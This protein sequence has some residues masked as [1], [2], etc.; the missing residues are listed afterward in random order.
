MNKNLD[1]VQILTTQKIQKAF[2]CLQI[3][4]SH[5]IFCYHPQLM[6]FELRRRNIKIALKMPYEHAVNL[7]NI[8]LICCYTII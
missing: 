2:E 6:R 3:Y 5:H 1:K 4:N 7:L 8:F